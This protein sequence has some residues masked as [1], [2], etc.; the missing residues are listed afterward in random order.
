MILNVMVSIVTAVAVSEPPFR[1][2]KPKSVL[3]LFVLLYENPPQ[4]GP[5]VWFTT[6]KSLKV[7]F[8]CQAP[9]PVTGPAVRVSVIVLPTS[10]HCEIF[11]MARFVTPAA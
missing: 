10:L 2:V 6:L 5:R 4:E 11:P 8:T 9:K 3:P 1:K 7:I